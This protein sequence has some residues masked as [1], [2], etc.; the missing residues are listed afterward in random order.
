MDTLDLHGRYHDSVQTV[1]ENF[2]LLNETPL[3]IIT[4]NSHRM[5]EMVFQILDYHKFGYHYENF[6]NYG[7]LIVINKRVFNSI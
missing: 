1:V 3:R 5:K 2:V 6:N 7:S 4:G